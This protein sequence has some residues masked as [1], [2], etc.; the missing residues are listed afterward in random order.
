MTFY[1][2]LQLNAAQ[3]KSVIK[4]SKTKKEKFYHIAVYI[5]KV[6]ITV[7]FA[8]AAIMLFTTFC[9]DENRMAGVVVLLS[10]LLFRNINLEIKMSH[11]FLSLF[12]IYAVLIFAPH[13]ANLANGVHPLAALP[14]HL[15]SIFVIAFLGCRNLNTFNQFVLVLGYLLLYGY[16]V[17][18]KSYLLRIA[19]MSVGLSLVMLIYFVKHKGNL[20]DATL[21]NLF[22]EFNIRSRRTSWQIKLTLALSTLLTFAELVGLKRGMWA[23]I[24]AMSV[25]VPLVKD[26]PKRAARRTIGNIA[27][28]AVFTAIYCIL[29]ESVVQLVGIFGGLGT[30]FSAKYK[31][32]SMFNSLGAM[33]MAVVA[34][35]S[36]QEAV[37]YRI[38]NN[39]VGAVYGI[40][41]GLVF[42]K[43]GALILK[44]I[45]T[46]KKIT[47]AG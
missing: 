22:K 25:L 18:G 30:G 15:I 7:L 11:S 6:I 36:L 39:V 3:S 29:P 19:G 27:G 9:G 46:K 24:A 16:D 33:S 35:G 47:N 26:I 8:I 31:W 17:S 14:V 42:H 44:G 12:I 4:D 43:I 10:V 23:G 38:V 41:F 32:Q 13:L 21:K 2:E 37:L 20:P 28:G 5:F 1:K 45:H 34:L 40:L